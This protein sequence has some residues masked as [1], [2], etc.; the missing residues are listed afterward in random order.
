MSRKT[1]AY[2]SLPLHAGGELDE[3]E[4]AE[5]KAEMAVDPELAAEAR[6]YEN[7]FDDVQ[8][9]RE[10]R[11]D[12]D[13]EIGDLWPDI[14]ERLFA[15]AQAPSAGDPIVLRSTPWYRR[16]LARMS[17]VAALLLVSFSIGLTMRDFGG[18]M[19]GANGNGQPA[20]ENGALIPGGGLADSGFG[21]VDM[22]TSGD[23]DF[24][25]AGVFDATKSALP[26]YPVVD[27]DR[28]QSVENGVRVAGPGRIYRVGYPVDF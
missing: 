24:G 18:L 2:N 6:R 17:G 22:P 28:L 8:A 23:L 10:I 19:P 7:A 25:A 27:A 1:R 12:F 21:T 11:P 9:V 14:R 13:E 16:P 4:R 3:R 5:L 26:V 15:E 20:N